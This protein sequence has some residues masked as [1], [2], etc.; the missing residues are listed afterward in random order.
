M[1]S[2]FL[3][4][5]SGVAGVLMFK[6]YDWAENKGDVT[7][8][9]C[10]Y[11]VSFLMVVVIVAFFAAVVIG[12][13]AVHGKDYGFL[14]SIITAFGCT[15]LTMITGVLLMLPKGLFRKINNFNA[16]FFWNKKHDLSSFMPKLLTWEIIIVF[17]LIMIIFL[18]NDLWML[19]VG[20]AALVTIF[21]TV[22]V[23][24][25]LMGIYIL[26]LLLDYLILL[27]AKPFKRKK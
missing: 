25:I 5:L 10:N 19:A 22:V 23:L 24:I 21:F 26:A 14:L 2:F 17:I 4:L 27:A 20:V 15:L 12:S 9:R 8:K 18:L 7:Q 16:I 11:F 1:V 13:Y 3:A 6:V